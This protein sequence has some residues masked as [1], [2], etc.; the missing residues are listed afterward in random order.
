MESTKNSILIDQFEEIVGL[1]KNRKFKKAIKQV[2]PIHVKACEEDKLKVVNQTSCYLLQAYYALG[3]YRKAFYYGND[4]LESL[5]DKQ[6]SSDSKSCFYISMLYYELEEYA[7]GEYYMRK[8]L[9][10]EEVMEDPNLYIQVKLNLSQFCINLDKYA[11]AKSF[12]DDVKRKIDGL[13][14]PA[15]IFTYYY[16]EII[17]RVYIKTGEYELANR[18]LVISRSMRI[19]QDVESEQLIHQMTECLYY[20]ALGKDK[21]LIEGMLKGYQQ[22]LR[23]DNIGY[24]HDFL[25]TIYQHR[26]KIIDVKERLEYIEEYIF[27]MD[28]F[29]SIKRDNYKT[30]LAS[31]I[32]KYKLHSEVNIDHLTGLKNRACFEKYVNQLSDYKNITC[33]VYDIDDFKGINDIYG[34]QVGDEVL[35]KVANISQDYFGDIGLVARYGG[36]EFII[37]IKDE[38]MDIGE[39]KANAQQMINSVQ[40]F[41]HTDVDRVVSISI[42]MANSRDYEIEDISELV[43]Q[44]DMNLYEAKR[45]GKNQMVIKNYGEVY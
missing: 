21:L 26:N 29:H 15:E 17:C 16:H 23:F 44:A 45:L 27:M 5:D 33:V 34:H 36:D 30:G 42:G 7:K 4:L 2:L 14:S 39:I 41:K 13:G 32:E 28:E 38:G 43:Y 20:E 25:K 9:E 22:A 1:L 37:L 31:Q 8:I 6:V 11:E 10:M 3:D 40:R 12:M 19:Y 35:T 18:H 24:K